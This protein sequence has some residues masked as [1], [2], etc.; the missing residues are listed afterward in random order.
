[1]QRP[2]PGVPP[3]ITLTAHTAPFVKQVTS[4]LSGYTGAPALYPVI[5]YK[6]D[7]CRNNPAYN[8]LCDV[9]RVHVNRNLSKAALNFV[10]IELDWDATYTPPVDAVAVGLNGAQEPNLDMFVWD[11]ADHVMDHFAV[12][13]VSSTVPERVAF[14]ATQDEFDVVV[15][16]SN[17]VS[18][19]Y[20]I[21][22]QT[23]DQ[24]YDKPFELLDPV[25]G[26]PIALPSDSSDTG[27]VVTPPDYSDT[28][29]T[30]ELPLQAID[31]DSQISGIGLGTTEQFDAS[32]LMRLGR[33]AARNTAAVSKPPSSVILVV[34]LVLLPLAILA[35][36]V[37]FLRRRRNVI[38]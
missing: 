10:V 26:Q 37:G 4:A 9:Y 25:T 20:K 22:A 35:A 38:I 21:T 3:D 23:T 1:V 5:Q 18:S 13:G 33:A 30:P 32:D 27:P 7:A 6:P 14:T 12:G 29:A 16:L 2:T 19:G 31:N 34:S 15:Q 24:I 28:S 8:G 36:G 11:T 17:G